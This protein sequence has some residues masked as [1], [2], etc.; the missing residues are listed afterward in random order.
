MHLSKLLKKKLYRLEFSIGEVVISKTVIPP[1]PEA[2][3]SFTS[4]EAIRSKGRTK[5]TALV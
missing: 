4:V 5:S 3:T 1:Y 2:L